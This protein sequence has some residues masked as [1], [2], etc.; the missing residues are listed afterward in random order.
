MNLT[1]YVY[2]V[3]CV[4]LY[5][6]FTFQIKVFVGILFFIII[7]IIIFILDWIFVNTM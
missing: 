2:N 4:Y 3:E 6:S 7:D 5:S 1:L